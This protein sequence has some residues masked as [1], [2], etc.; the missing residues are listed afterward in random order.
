MSP[1]VIAREC[2]P[3]VLVTEER[4]VVAGRTMVLCYPAKDVSSH[5]PPLNG[6]IT[7]F[8]VFFDRHRFMA[9]EGVLVQ[10]YTP[11][12]PEDSKDALPLIAY[13]PAAIASG[14]IGFALGRALLGSCLAATLACLA[15]GSAGAMALVFMMLRSRK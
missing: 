7:N 11:E 6:D 2:G 3:R 8:A 13:L 14:M 10:A 12:D 5:R 4:R 9:V 1:S 15:A